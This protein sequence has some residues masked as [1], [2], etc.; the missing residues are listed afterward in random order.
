MSGGCCARWPPLPWRGSFPSALT[1]FAELPRYLPA[2][3]SLEA[4]ASAIAC[5]L[6]IP[7]CTSLA[8]L[9]SEV[10]NRLDLPAEAALGSHHDAAVAADADAAGFFAASY[11]SI[12]F[13][14]CV[15]LLDGSIDQG[16]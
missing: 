1:A 2:H 5:G 14:L 11:A 6:F 8:L 10:I 7:G 9:F 13:C 4:A 15:L 3:Y 12:C 16:Q